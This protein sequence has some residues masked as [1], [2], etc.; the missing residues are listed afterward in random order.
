M[1][2]AEVV[3]DEKHCTG[4]GY[5]QIFCPKGCIVITGEKL[6]PQGYPLP[7]L[8]EAEKCKACGICAYMCPAFAIE[9]YRIRAGKKRSP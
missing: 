3:I 6:T 2:Q 5:C 4:C 8:V 1:A 9:V 7:T